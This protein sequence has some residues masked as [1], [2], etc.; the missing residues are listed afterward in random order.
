MKLRLKPILRLRG[1]S[2]QALA[3]AIGVNKSFISDIANGKKLPGTENLAA[4]A[5]ALDVDIGQLVES[6][7]SV[8]VAGRVGAGAAVQLVDGYEKGDGLYHVACPDDLPSRNIVA[9]EVEGD[10][11]EPLINHGDVLFFTRHFVGID[12]NAIKR[13]A[14][15]E[16]EEGRA[17]VKKVM[18]GREPG[19]FDLVS[20]NPTWP[21]EYGV[22]LKWAAPLRRPI[23][24]EDV[25]R[26]E[27]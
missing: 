23:A 5:D 24:A 15:L 21:V 16:T 11:G 17:L 6:T 19:T 22:R 13:V 10:S 26:I 14:I 8:A 2:Q 3:D 9:V 7:R 20:I 27:I 4:I 1:I 12:E 25:Q 18:P